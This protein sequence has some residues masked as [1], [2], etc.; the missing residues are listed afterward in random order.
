MT[1]DPYGTRCPGDYEDGI[2]TFDKL[3]LVK[4][5]RNELIQ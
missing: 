3:L 4:V 2:S 5:F 1:D